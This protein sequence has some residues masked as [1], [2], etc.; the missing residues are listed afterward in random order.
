MARL[1]R[2]RRRRRQDA[3]V[4]P[5]CCDPKPGIKSR[6]P[7]ICSRCIRLWRDSVS[8][9]NKVTGWSLTTLHILP[10][11]SFSIIVIS[12][13]PCLL[14][15]LSLSAR[16]SPLS[17]DALAL[18]LQIS[19]CFNLDLCDKLARSPALSLR[20]PLWS[21]SLALL[22]PITPFSFS[23]SFH[24]TLALVSSAFS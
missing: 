14:L 3:A 6:V 19:R 21:S 7:A 8:H 12:R 9:L 10:S 13:S 15:F 20:R 16:L 2:R 4:E 24:Q 18:S 22:L 5:W 1:S 11:L 23:S 17:N